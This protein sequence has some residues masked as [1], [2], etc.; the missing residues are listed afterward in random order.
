[1]TTLITKQSTN[2][3]S[4]NALKLFSNRK[5]IKFCRT[6]ASQIAGNTSNVF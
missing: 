4:G 2:E 1:M 3:I 6:L 5:A